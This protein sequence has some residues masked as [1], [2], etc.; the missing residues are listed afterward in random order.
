VQGRH[1]LWDHELRAVNSVAVGVMPVVRTTPCG[2]RAYVPHR[3]QP[4]HDFHMVGGAARHLAITLRRMYQTRYKAVGK[5]GG[6]NEEVGNAT[7]TLT[8]TLSTPTDICARL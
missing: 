4:G 1:P 3:W 2:K 7:W 5:H 8:A 6:D